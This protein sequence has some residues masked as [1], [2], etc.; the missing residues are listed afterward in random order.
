MRSEK[1][2]QKLVN[3]LEG[4]AVGAIHAYGPLVVARK[5]FESCMLM[6]D[7]LKW[8]LGEDNHVCELVEKFKE[9]DKEV[10]SAPSNLCQ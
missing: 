9:I 5:E 4:S 2:I 3:N 8:V 1:E 6:S 7:L 10:P